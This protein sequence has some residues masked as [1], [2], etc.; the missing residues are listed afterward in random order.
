MSV[1]LYGDVNAGDNSWR[2]VKPLDESFVVVCGIVRDAERGL[3]TNIPVEHL[4]GALC[5][6]GANL[7]RQ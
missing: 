6:L 7:G 1:A 5:W 2:W 3:K 4:K